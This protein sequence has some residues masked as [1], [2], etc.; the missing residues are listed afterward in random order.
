MSDRRFFRGLEVEASES[1]E[2]D[3]ALRVIRKVINGLLMRVCLVEQ[4]TSPYAAAFT[5]ELRRMEC[6]GFI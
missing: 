1:T 3:C 5:A 6:L 4:H 2:R